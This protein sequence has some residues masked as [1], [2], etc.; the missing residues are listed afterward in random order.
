MKL[1]KLLHKTERFSEFQWVEEQKA[2]CFSV[3][4]A[5]VSPEWKGTKQ[6]R[7]EKVKTNKKATGNHVN[8]KYETET[9]RINN[10]QK[11]NESTKENIK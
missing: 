6:P 3:I 9:K 11:Q 1:S 7:N 4:L 8:R 10:K 2:D 5:T